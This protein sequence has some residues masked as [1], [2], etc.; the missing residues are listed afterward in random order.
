MNKK[1]LIIPITILSV[2]IIFSAFFILIKNENK[3]EIEQL[4]ITTTTPDISENINTSRWETYRN[5]EFGFEFRHPSEADG[6]IYRSPAYIRF[7]STEELEAYKLEL[8]KH[9]SDQWTYQ[10]N[11]NLFGPYYVF[12]TGIQYEGGDWAISVAVIPKKIDDFLTDKNYEDIGK[13]WDVKKREEVVLEGGL[14]VEKVTWANDVIH[15]YI[16]KEGHP[17]T[18]EFS[19]YNGKERNKFNNNN[20]ILLKI[21]SS[22]RFIG[23]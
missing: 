6:W 15:F 11:D 8:K 13:Y 10:T 20:K 4:S 14:K 21:I 2:A 1:A 19:G 9:K 18:I 16:Q 17:L 23:N 12:G 7:T 22:L 3:K 5:E